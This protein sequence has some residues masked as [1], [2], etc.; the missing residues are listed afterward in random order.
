MAHRTRWAI[1]LASLL[2]GASACN[3]YRLEP[4]TGF[5]EVN[6]HDTGARMKA[7][8]NVGLN[9]TVFE[10]VRGGTLEFWS[11]D[12]VRKLAARGYTLLHHEPVRSDNGKSGTRFDFA[13][14]NR[15]DEE[16][17]Y[18]VLLFVTDK[19]RVVVEVAGNEALATQYRPRLASIAGD[20]KVRGCKPGGDLCNGE[21]AKGLLAAPPPAKTEKPEETA[22]GDTVV[23]PSG[24]PT[25]PV[26]TATD[27]KGS[28]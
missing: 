28:P 18:S 23:P 24:E 19:H 15:E 6:H 4:P 26:D 10:N 1:A 3:A 9:V 20:L 5:A 25:A 13:Y 22:A 12:L 8:D 11:T 27:S 16:K 7:G 14:K 2:L 21:Q 17:F